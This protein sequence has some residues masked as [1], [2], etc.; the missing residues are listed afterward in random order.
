MDLIGHF[1]NRSAQGSGWILFDG[2]VT[3]TLGILVWKH[4][5][6]SSVWVIGNRKIASR[7][8]FPAGTITALR[9]RKH[10]SGHMGAILAMR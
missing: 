6:S 8:K 1:E 5:P 2:I 7:M 4:W 3:L 10:T 9:R